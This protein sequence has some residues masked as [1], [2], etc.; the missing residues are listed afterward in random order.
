MSEILTEEDN[1][2]LEVAKI[3]YEAYIKTEYT[4]KGRE[5]LAEYGVDHLAQDVALAT[6]Q[7]LRDGE[8]NFYGDNKPEHTHKI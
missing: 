5:V 3:V 4:G 7:A 6:I 8:F 1:R 2:V